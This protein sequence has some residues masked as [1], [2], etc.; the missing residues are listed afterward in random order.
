MYSR[1]LN[2]FVGTSTAPAKATLQ[3]PIT[4]V[5]S[6]GRLRRCNPLS[7]LYHLENASN[8]RIF[9][10]ETYW[11]SNDHS[12]KPTVRSIRH[13]MRYVLQFLLIWS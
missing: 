3:P 1:L 13:D 4:P 9:N 2:F 12:F 7:I 10:C 5:Q 6:Q 11:F 8:K